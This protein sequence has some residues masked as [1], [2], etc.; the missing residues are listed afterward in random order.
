MDVDKISSMFNLQTE[1]SKLNILIRFNELLKNQEYRNTI[2]KMISNE[3]ETHPD[4]L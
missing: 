1:L 2:T 3:G 4:M